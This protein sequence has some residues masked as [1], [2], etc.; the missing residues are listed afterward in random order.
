ML[1]SCRVDAEYVEWDA[2]LQWNLVDSKRNSLK[3][4]LGRLSWSA[5]V[6]SVWKLRND[7]RQGN[8]LRTEEKILMQI[9]WEVRARILAK[10]R[11]CRNYENLLLCN[12]WGLTDNILV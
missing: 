1:R 9:K 2:V 4:A 8:P 11:F 6:Y 5:C 3:A 10:G 7:I 12:S